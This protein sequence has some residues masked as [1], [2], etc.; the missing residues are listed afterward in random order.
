[1]PTL[2][3]LLATLR[4]QHE[5]LSQRHLPAHPHHFPAASLSPF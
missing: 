2:E 1:M 4:N 5:I 3:E